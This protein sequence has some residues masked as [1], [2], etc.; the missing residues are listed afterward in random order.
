MS[1]FETITVAGFGVW[2][3][4]S[5]GVI[6]GVIKPLGRDRFRFA[7]RWNLFSAGQDSGQAALAI[8]LVDTRTDG[9]QSKPISLTNGVR[10]WRPSVPFWSGSLL[11][12]VL[13]RRLAK[14]MIRTGGPDPD[15]YQRLRAIALRHSAAKDVVSRRFQI[16]AE[17]SASPPELL[18]E[19]SNEPL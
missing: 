2:L 5:L 18:F 7:P 6:T 13:L 19:S 1:P 14:A 9:S 17:R 12:V 15:A 8:Y 11:P 16:Y 4:I 3:I 10:P